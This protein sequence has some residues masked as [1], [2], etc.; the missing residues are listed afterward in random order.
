MLRLISRL[1]KGNAEQALLPARPALQK[2]R[3]RR[4]FHIFP[5]HFFPFGGNRIF[6]NVSTGSPIRLAGLLIWRLRNLSY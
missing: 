2:N 5:G 3:R 1:N 6:G 4:L